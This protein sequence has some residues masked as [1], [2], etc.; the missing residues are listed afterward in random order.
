MEE[1]NNKRKKDIR[2]RFGFA[3][4]TGE[5]PP[6]SNEKSSPGTPPAGRSN[7]IF[8]EDGT[9]SMLSVIGSNEF[10]PHP[11]QGVTDERFLRKN[12][13]EYPENKGASVN[14]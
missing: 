7:D 9:I 3:K 8:V 13:E 4:G 12:V 11:G 10:A 2:E 5:S 14:K 1:A 6:K